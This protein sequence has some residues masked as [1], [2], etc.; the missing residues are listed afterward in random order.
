MPSPLTPA[1][2][3]PSCEVEPGNQWHHIDVR[4]GPL[5]ST[6]HPVADGENWQKIA[7][8]PEVQ[9]PDRQIP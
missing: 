3:H 8:N 7:A 9:G 1:P 2:L 5:G 6:A 4:G